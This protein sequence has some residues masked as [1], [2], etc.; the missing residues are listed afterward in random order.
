MIN[1]GDEIAKM[2]PI[3]ISVSDS[4]SS[5]ISKNVYKSI[6]L[7]NKAIANL[8]N[9]E[10]TFAIKNLKKSLSYNR[11]F[12]Q[13]MKLLGLCYAY[14]NDFNSAEKYFKKLDKYAM[15][16]TISKDYLNEL[17]TQKVN[18]Q[19]LNAIRKYSS[20]S[21]TSKKAIFS[22]KIVVFAL[23]PV[24]AIVII[25][26]VYKI[27]PNIQTLL[28]TK[29]TFLHKTSAIPEQN[30]INDE[31][32]S[33][34]NE[35]YLTVKNSLDSTK[36]E[37]DSYKNKYNSLMELN[38]AEILYN[39]GDY[40]KAIDVLIT[41]KN[42]TLDD[43]L[44]ARFNALWDYT[45]SDAVW[46]IYKE[47]NN[48]YK[49]EKYSEALP[50]L[51]KVAEINPDEKLMP[52]ILYQIGMCYKNSNDSTNALLYLKKVKADYPNSNYAGYAD[53][54]IGQIVH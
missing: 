24:A 35:N 28:I 6:V 47:A 8:R 18:F 1:F 33:K 45:K 22:K 37:L 42:L 17:N 29:K 20:K 3:N 34:L 53:R 44:K 39:D 13:S 12:F 16:K 26:S 41:L 36:S 19:A 52:W 2:T 25:F 4:N 23:V 32:Y 11:G 9:T 14:N 5:H 46:K 43:T 40:E 21:K 31:K 54:I 51:K 48:L 38:N 50:K 7:Y 15:Y 30:N 10:T 27:Y 49:Q